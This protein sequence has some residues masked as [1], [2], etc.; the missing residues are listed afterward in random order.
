MAASID[1]VERNGAGGTTTVKT[2]GTVRM[3]LADNATVDTN[4]PLTVPVS[5]TTFSFQKYVQ[6]YLNTPPSSSISNVRAYTTTASTPFGTGVTL[7]WKTGS[8]YTQP[9]QETSAASYTNLFGGTAGAATY[10]SGS[11]LTISSGQVASGATS[12]G[13]IGNMLIMCMT[14]D[15]T[16]S[17]GT[18]S[19][20]NLTVSY[21]EV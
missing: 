7:Y 1:I 5:G 10:T 18:L 11:P 20:A 14:V 8:S 13:L 4:N 21:D 19:A 16:A 2:S 6:L 17:S 15:S 3:K 12:A 9:V